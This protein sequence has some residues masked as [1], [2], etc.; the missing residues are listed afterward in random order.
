MA[1][2]TPTRVA[3]DLFEAAA[4]EGALEQRSAKGQID[5]WA[6]I[7][8]KVTMRD[9]VLR[10][11]IEKCFSGQLPWTALGPAE[12]RVAHA[13]LDVAI[14]DAAER[15]SLGAAASAVGIVTVALDDQG[16]LREY[17]PDGTTTLLA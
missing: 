9:T 17:R 7:G 11:R 16:R 6:R 5:Y 8:Q 4:R 12:Q 10:R 1:A 14:D 13:E 15:V 3:N 2:D